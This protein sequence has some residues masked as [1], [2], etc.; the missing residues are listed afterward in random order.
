MSPFT[1][2]PFLAL[3]SLICLSFSALPGSAAP[4]L[5]YG[6]YGGDA[7]S[8]A[9]DPTNHA[10]VYMGTINGWIYDS[11]DSGAHWSRMARVGKRDDLALDHILVN[12]LNPKHLMVGAWVLDHPDGGIYQSFDGGRT[13]ASQAQMQGQSI[14]ALTSSPSNPKVI[15]AGT[16]NGIFRSQDSGKSWNLIS[17][18]ESNEIHNF[19]SVAIAPD[20]PEVIYGGTR[21]LPWRTLDGGANWSNIKTGIIDDSDV[22][23]II[24]DPQNPQVVYASACSGIYKSEDGAER[25][26]KVQG[27]PSTARR[28]RVLKQDPEHLNIVFAGTTEG[29]WRT[30]DSGA[31]WKRTTGPE[32][33]VNDVFID[34][35]NTQHVL[36]AT[37]RGGVLLSED[38]GDSFVPA[39]EGFSA[40]QISAFLVDAARPGLM[41]VGIVNDKEWGGVFLSRDGGLSWFQRSEGLRGRDVFSLAQAPDGTLVA[42]TSHGIFRYEDIFWTRSLDASMLGDAPASVRKR[43]AA[44]AATRHGTA[45]KKTVHGKAKS[46]AKRPVAVAPVVAAAPLPAAEGAGSFDGMVHAIVTVGDRMYAASSHGLLVSTTSGK[47]WAPVSSMG[48]DEWRFLATDK[49]VVIASSLDKMMASTDGG[50]TWADMSLPPKVLQVTALAVDSRGAIWAAGREGIFVSSNNGMSWQ[51]LSNLYVRDVNSLYFDG[52]SNQLLVT[53]NGNAT[54]GFGLEVATRKVTY[55]DTGWTLRFLRPVGDHFLGATL[56]DGVVIQPRMIDAGQAV[57]GKVGLDGGGD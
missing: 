28:T 2:R 17:P 6:P 47:S 24:V 3:L 49:R 31:T 55:W 10:H 25:F 38:G 4:W 46:S 23:S 36:L 41:Y 27:I 52:K 5:P 50:A 21:H 34:T 7:R 26:R 57:G 18:P 22:F 33:I 13:W 32:V 16:L 37:D 29:L 30:N 54:I 9:A 20:N 43:S 44:K 45:G 51:T 35:T 15:V 42:G 8:F 19:Q 12:P 14:R 40:R 48:G 11:Q 1:V 39:N 53:A 56:F